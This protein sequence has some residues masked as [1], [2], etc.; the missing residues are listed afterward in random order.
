MSLIIYAIYYF[1]ICL[2]GT[3]VLIIAQIIEVIKTVKK[4]SVG[5][6]KGIGSSVNKD[7]CILIVYPTKI[8]TIIPIKQLE[9]TKVNAS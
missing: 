5:K 4:I 1:I 9:N 7:L 8:P 6:A 2:A 3:Y